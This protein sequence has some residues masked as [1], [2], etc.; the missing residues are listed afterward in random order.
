MKLSVISHL[1]KPGGGWMHPLH[2]PCVRAWVE[3]VMISMKTRLFLMGS[4][5]WKIKL[6]LI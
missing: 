6:G 4:V 3:A 5:Y 2:P 1:F